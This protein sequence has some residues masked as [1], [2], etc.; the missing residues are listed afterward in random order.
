MD[1]FYPELLGGTVEDPF[2]KMAEGIKDMR[3]AATGWSFSPTLP[4]S[5]A[6]K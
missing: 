5:A 1:K 4:V 6:C 2:G 3:P